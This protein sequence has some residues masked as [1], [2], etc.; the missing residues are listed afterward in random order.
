MLHLKE[1]VRALETKNSQILR[2]ETTLR[3]TMLFLRAH[4]HCV[5]TT[6]FLSALPALITWYTPGPQL[7]PNPC[8]R[9]ILEISTEARFWDWIDWQGWSSWSLFILYYC[10]KILFI[11]QRWVS[12]MASWI[13]CCCVWE[14]SSPTRNQVSNILVS[15]QQCQNAKCPLLLNGILVHLWLQGEE[16]EVDTGGGAIQCHLSTAAPTVYVLPYI[17]RFPWVKYIPPKHSQFIHFV[18]PVETLRISGF[19][20]SMPDSNIRI[21]RMNLLACF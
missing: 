11:W 12:A 14:S 13:F 9:E 5:I 4:N 6:D 7:S 19:S 15:K 3:M 1:P 18:F 20:K 21:I 8:V 2:I 17:N 16:V 10:F